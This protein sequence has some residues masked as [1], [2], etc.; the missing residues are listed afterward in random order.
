MD[1]VKL[2]KPSIEMLDSYKAALRQGW[3]PNTTRPEAAN[4]ELESISQHPNDFI[5]SLTDLDAKGALIKMPDGSFSKRI[6]GFKRWIWDGEF[7]GVIDFRW[8]H[9][10]E[11]LPPTVLGHVGYSVVPWKRDKGYASA[12][13]SQL[14]EQL[15]FTKLSYITITT[16]PDNRAS[17]RVAEKCGAVLYETFQKPPEFG[18]KKAYRYRINLF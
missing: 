15:D 10:T 11:E 12:A 6:P 2:L 8:Q 17:Q 1:N 5:A 14:L 4:E 9:G 16:D 18:G 7:C 13:L 3:S